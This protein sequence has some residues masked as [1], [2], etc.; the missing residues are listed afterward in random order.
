MSTSSLEFLFKPLMS[1]LNE[2]REVMRQRKIICLLCDGKHPRTNS[3]RTITVADCIKKAMK[4]VMDEIHFIYVPHY[5]EKVK[6]ELTVTDST[7]IPYFPM[8]EDYKK[9]KLQHLLSLE[10]WTAMRFWMRVSDLRKENGEKF[11]ELKILLDS[12]CVTR[13]SMAVIDRDG[14]VLTSKGRQIVD[15]FDRGNNEAK[16][17]TEDEAR[18]LVGDMMKGDS[19]EERK[20]AARQLESCLSN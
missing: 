6:K 11:L 20:E 12:M 14:E 2:L 18:K 5:Q 8:V 16:G 3:V 10:H 1:E 17:L 15:I 9:P 13:L 19:K 7:K 4:D